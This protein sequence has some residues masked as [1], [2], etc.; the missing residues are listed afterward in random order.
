MMAVDL[1]GRREM[2]DVRAVKE[3]AG[4]GLRSLENLAFQL[5][6]QRSSADCREIPD[7]TVSKLKKVISVLNRTGHARFRRGPVVA[8]PAVGVHEGFSETPEPAKAEAQTAPPPPRLMVAPKALTLDFAKSTA[9]HADTALTLSFSTSAT[10]SSANSSFLSSLTGD[11]SV[12]NGKI[13]PI[14]LSAAPVPAPAT[15]APSSGRPPLASSHKKICLGEGH[16]HAH[17]SLSGKHAGGRCHCS[18]KK[19]PRVKKTIRVPSISSRNADIPA[20]E[21]SWRK[22]GQKPIKGSPYPRGYYKC[23]SVR[24]CPARKHVERAPQDPSMLIVTYEGEHR[25]TAAAAAA[26]AAD[27]RSHISHSSPVVQPF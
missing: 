19:K 18:K 27:P 3:A 24:G 14:I 8:A 21:Y 13:G 10:S 17:N 5:S 25:H 23:S 1:Q 16:S 11:G 20:D 22:Y 2:D 4:A 7:L 12:S 9:D 15:A 6:L 26:A